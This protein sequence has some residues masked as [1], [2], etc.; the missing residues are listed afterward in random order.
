MSG[1]AHSMS[2]LVKAANDF[3]FNSLAMST[4]QTYGSALNSYLNCYTEFGQQAP[5]P[6]TQ[7]SLVLWLTHCAIRT[8]RPLAPSTLRTYLSGLCSLHEEM[9]YRNLLEDKPLVHRCF[10]G[11]KKSRGASTFVRRPITTKVLAQIKTKLNESFQ[12]TVYYAAATLAT[13]G[14]LRMGEF[15]ISGSNKSNA[16]KLLTLQQLTLMKEN[17]DPIHVSDVS[18]Y[19]LVTRMSITL[20]TSKTDPFRKQ[21]TIQIGHSTPVQ[22]MLSYLRIHPLLHDLSSPLFLE[23]V[24]SRVPLTRDNMIAATRLLLHELGYKENEFHGH[25]FRKGGATSLFEAGVADSIIQLIGRWTSDCYKLYIVTPLET[26]LEASRA[27]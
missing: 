5:F 27:L 18:Q 22:A 23:S 4:R 16:F 9:G 6:A 7:Q 14:L 24:S 21:V 11:I 13:Y 8:V 12:C 26:L 2:H 17:G 15:T 20:R 1:V 19:G 25:S 3:I 10:R